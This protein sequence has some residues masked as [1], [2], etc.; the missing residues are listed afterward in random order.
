M[1]IRSGTRIGLVFALLSGFVSVSAWAQAGSQDL[2]TIVPATVYS[3]SESMEGPLRVNVKCVLDVNA[4]S[5]AEPGRTA[6]YDA[7]NL[8]DGD[9]ATSWVEG[10][11]DDGVGE[12]VFFRF[13]PGT[14]VTTFFVQNGY[15]ASEKLWNQNGRVK[16]LDYTVNFADGSKARGSVV[17]PNS[18]DIV[19]FRIGA[20][21]SET[22][23]A[24]SMEFVIRSVYKGTAYTD[25]C[26]SLLAPL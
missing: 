23:S 15:N 16:Q 25:T 24:E 19:F 13:N 9:P 10:K 3:Y 17:L 20:K 12:G 11:K 18:R 8:L 1:S 2:E 14:K 5:T 22:V 6:T 7:K 26:I 21:K 4:S